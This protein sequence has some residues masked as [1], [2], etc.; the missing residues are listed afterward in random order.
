MRGRVPTLPNSKNGTKSGRLRFFFQI[1][2]GG[3]RSRII[4]LE[5][6]ARRPLIL[7]DDNTKM[8][9]MELIP[10]TTSNVQRHILSQI[11]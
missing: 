6:F 11:Q 4:V 3:T 1:W 2:R 7:S 9:T 8:D 5:V 10:A